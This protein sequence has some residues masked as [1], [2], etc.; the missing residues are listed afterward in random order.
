MYNSYIEKLKIFPPLQVSMPKRSGKKNKDNAS[1][2]AALE[3][4]TNAILQ[5]VKANQSQ[6]EKPKIVQIVI[7]ESSV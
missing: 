1:D 5:E 7:Y 2:M 6:P 3:A 4:I